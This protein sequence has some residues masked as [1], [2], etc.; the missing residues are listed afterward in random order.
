MRKDIRQFSISSVSDSPSRLKPFN[1]ASFSVFKVNTFPMLSSSSLERTVISHPFFSN[2]FL[3]ALYCANLWKSS[4]SFLSSLAPVNVSIS[5]PMAFFNIFLIL[6]ELAFFTS[7]IITSFSSFDSFLPL[8]V[9]LLR[10][11]NKLNSCAVYVAPAARVRCLYTLHFPISFSNIL[12][13]VIYFPVS[14]VLVVYLP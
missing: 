4:F 11:F 7:L 12:S 14:S 8:T 9:I 2:S 13:S 10:S 1:I 5:S 3:I 6:N